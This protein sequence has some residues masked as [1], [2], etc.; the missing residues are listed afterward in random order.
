MIPEAQWRIGLRVRVDN[1]AEDIFADVYGEYA[2]VWYND[3]TLFLQ[4][5]KPPTFQTYGNNLYW[6]KE[7]RG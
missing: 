4:K 1:E 2:I 5:V 3:S 7:G 6:R